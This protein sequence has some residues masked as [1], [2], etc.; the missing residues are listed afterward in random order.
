MQE[1]YNIYDALHIWHCLEK[2][3]DGHG[4]YVG[5]IAEIYVQYLLPTDYDASAGKTLW[6]QASK[7]LRQII[8]M[9]CN[10]HYVDAFINGRLVG[11]W[12]DEYQLLHKCEVRIAAKEAGNE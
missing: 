10:T 2:A 7:N 1:R 9:F 8:T 11:E 5:D 4:M 3:K 6:L 12:M